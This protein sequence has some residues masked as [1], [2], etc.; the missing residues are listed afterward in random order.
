MREQSI[1]THQFDNG[2]MLIVEPMQ[3]VQSASFSFLVPAGSVFDGEGKNGSAAMLADWISRGAGDRDSRTLSSTLDNLGLQRNDTAGTQHITFAGALVADRLIDS[4]KLYADILRRPLLPNEQF[5]SVQLGAEQALRAVEDEPQ[6]KALVE[7][8]RNSFQKPW[9][10]PS[11]GT[12]ADLENITA[13][14]VREH[15]DR[16]FRPNGAILGIAGNVDFDDMVRAT[17]EFYGDWK[18]KPEVETVPGEYGAKRITIEHESSQTHIGLSYPSVPYSDPDYYAAWAAVGV[19]SGGSSSRL[20]TE[21]REKRGLCYSVSAS[22]QSMKHEGR[23]VCYAGTQNERAQET[24]DVTLDEI[25]KLGDGIEV[26]ELDRCKTRAKSS[27]IMQQE[28]TYARSGS[29]ARDWFYLG[30]ITTL[31]EVRDKIDELTPETVLDFIHRN[32]P[33]DFNI[34]T[35]GPQELTFDLK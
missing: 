18:E 11:D 6:Q 20:F 7:L 5:E 23:V 22:L 14:S 26:A 34:L 32:P 30:R 19:L 24:L 10:L 29:I 9:S 3:D 25:K 17:D 33:K 28:S 2:L 21:V 16:S 1:R 4:L 8:R 12:L 27:L 15:Y 35:I 13:E 31:Q